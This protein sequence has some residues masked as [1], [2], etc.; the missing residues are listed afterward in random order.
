MGFPTL[1]LETRT[2]MFLDV[3]TFHSSPPHYSHYKLFVATHQSIQGHVPLGWTSSQ[4]KNFALY[5]WVAT[6][7][8]HFPSSNFQFPP[9]SSQNK[10][11]R[12]QM[13][14]FFFFFLA[15]VF[16][17]LALFLHQAMLL[18]CIFTPELFSI[19]GSI[20][21]LGACM[22]MGMGQHQKQILVPFIG[23][24]SRLLWY[25]HKA[26]FSTEIPGDWWCCCNYRSREIILTLEKGEDEQAVIRPY[27]KYR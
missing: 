20:Q 25:K 14:F 5:T 10:R 26:Y 2:A 7:Q 13:A 8:R 22:D 21:C 6:I 19:P 9:F 3:H 24:I 12:L 23:G 11:V 15:I 4:L 18:M 27:L 17:Q 16:Q 1:S